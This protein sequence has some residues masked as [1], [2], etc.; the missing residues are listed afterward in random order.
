MTITQLKYVLAIAEYKNFTVASQH[1]FVT[2]PTLSMQ[3]Q[4]LEEELGVQLFNRKKKPIQL[5]VIGERIIEQAKIIVDES[6]RL[7]DIVDQQ[8]GYVGG[9]FKL[10][11]IPTIMPTLLPMFLSVFTKKFPKVKLSIEE[12]TT[13]EIIKKLVDGHL[14]AAI[15]ATPLENKMLKELPL[16]YEPFVGFVP[17]N[18]PL[19]S[20]T[21]LEP[22]DLDVDT[23]LLLE[24]GHCFKENILNI[25]KSSKAKQDQ[26][27][28][29]E[30][31]SF[32]TL[33]KLAKEGL[34]M[35]LLPYL[36]TL[37]LTDDKKYLRNFTNPAPAREVSLVFHKAHLKVQ[38]IEALKSTIDSVVRGAIAF[39]DVK[40]ISPLPNKKGA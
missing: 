31:G 38:M 7:Q 21:T 12:L 6:N 35:T 11:I 8:K 40:I 25:C 9:A 13:E 27:F 19:S 2:Q 32:D 24:D 1:C 5:T 18:H 34:G 17:D 23:M 15:A 37:D 10:G 14:D 29:L 22:E 33:I 39:Y 16:Y 26:K 36:H 20:K 28:K 3:V 4:K 30:S